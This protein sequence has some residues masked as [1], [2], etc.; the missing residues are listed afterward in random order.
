MSVS[1]IALINQRNAKLIYRWICEAEQ[2]GHTT[3]SPAFMLAVPVVSSPAER[4]CAKEPVN[5]IHIELP[6][7]GGPSSC[8]GRPIRSVL[9]REL[10]R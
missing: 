7:A 5:R 8:G 6:P 1:Q 2:A 3:T 4:F 10:L 9:L